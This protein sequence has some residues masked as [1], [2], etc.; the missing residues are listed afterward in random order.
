M[1]TLSL[2]LG[3]VGASLRDLYDE[4]LVLVLVNLLW[5]ILSLPVITLPPALMGMIYVTNRVARGESIRAGMFLDG[6]RRYFLAG[7]LF[8]LTNL[9]AGG[10]IVFSIQFYGRFEGTLTSMVRLLWLYIL[11]AWILV[12]LYALPLL[13][14][15]KEPRVSLALRNG[16]LLVARNPVFAILLALVVAL[17]VSLCVALAV[18]VALLVAA[19]VGLLLNRAVL[20]LLGKRLPGGPAPDTVGDAG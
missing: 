16:T 6:F 14:E 13:V 15:Q 20:A 1:R 2:L 4:M 11:V 17:E 3:V 5:F 8:A 10:F 7:W 9:V 18:P 19:M 12:Q